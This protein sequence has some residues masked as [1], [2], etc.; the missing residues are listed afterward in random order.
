MN[1]S[2]KTSI[3]TTATINTPY[4]ND[5]WKE[6]IRCYLDF[7]DEVIVVCGHHKDIQ[8]ITEEFG[9]NKKLVLNYM[10]WP[11]KWNWIEL[12]KHMNRGLELA[13]KE[14]IIRM[15][16]DYFIHEKDFKEFK[17]Q[18]KVFYESG[19]LIAKTL[20]VNVM[21]KYNGMIKSRNAN[22]ING[23]RKDAIRFG[24]AENKE[25]D[26]TVPTINIGSC[27]KPK[28]IAFEEADS[29]LLRTWIYNYDY[30]FCT[31]RDVQKEFWRFAQAYSAA[32][33]KSWG[34]TEEEAYDKWIRMQTG[35]LLKAGE[36]IDH[37]K[38][39]K[40]RIDK[41]PRE[42]WGYCNWDLIK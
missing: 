10:D 9:D 21:N 2:F 12:P 24:K 15:D 7:A 19:D 33:I 16:I 38:Y 5:P 42:E 17:E 6:A 37:P 26:W 23:R 20:K 31:K 4:R 30:F 11:Y 32:F 34:A 25:T 39:I 1:T 13:T 41:M 36:E 28:Y 40:K 3:I 29:K 14:V 18:L 35:R 27:K 22:V 8:T